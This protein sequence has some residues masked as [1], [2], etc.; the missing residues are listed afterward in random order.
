MRSLLPLVLL[1]T[2]G[3]AVLTANPATA[4]PVTCS[5]GVFSSCLSN[6]ASPAVRWGDGWCDG[7]TYD[8]DA[9]S[10]SCG[11]KLTLGP[12][13]V[14]SG[15][16][17]DAVRA[18][19]NCTT[20]IQ[21]VTYNQLGLTSHWKRFSPP[22]GGLEIN[23]SS[24][25]CYGPTG[26]T[27]SGTSSS[28]VSLAWNTIPSNSSDPVDAI[29]YRVFRS[30]ALIAVLPR[31]QGSFQDSGLPANSTYLYGVTV[32]RTYQ[33]SSASTVYGGT[34]APPPPTYPAET[35]PPY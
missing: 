23:V 14:T 13:S 32:Q 34:S 28:T 11:S 10:Y 9:E 35:A 33:E 12:A 25:T 19:A 8:L 4:A 17:V 22:L 6:N 2:V 1:M 24:K 26:L 18:D 29:T 7:S 15:V 3:V 27:V 5:P 20:V 31:T 30:G 21:G 16:D